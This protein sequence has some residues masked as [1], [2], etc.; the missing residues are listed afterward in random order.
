MIIKRLVNNNF[1]YLIYRLIFGIKS[2]SVYQLF[3]DDKITKYYQALVA[4]RYLAIENYYGMNNFGWDLYKKTLECRSNKK[5]EEDI[6]KFKRLINSFEVFGYKK[7][8]A[9]YLDKNNC[10]FNGTHRLALC[11]WSSIDTISACHVRRNLKYDSIENLYQ[12]F[13]FTSSE[14]QT[15][16]KAYSRIKEKS[17]KTNTRK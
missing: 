9:I 12:S 16:E 8:S 11:V 10:C 15:I 5:I 4:I 7:G 3:A 6:E 2:I 1:T 17:E 13:G 14:V